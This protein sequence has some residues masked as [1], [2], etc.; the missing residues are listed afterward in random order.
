[1]GQFSHTKRK[2]Q[3]EIRSDQ[4]ELALRL[5]LIWS[6]SHLLSNRR[7]YPERDFGT[8]TQ[9]RRRPSKVIGSKTK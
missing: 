8:I 3:S 1:M 9:K 6:I 2:G 5:D 7:Y 4:Q